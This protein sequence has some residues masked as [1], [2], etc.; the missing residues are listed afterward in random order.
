MGNDAMPLGLSMAMAQDTRAMNGFFSLSD[1]QK[2]ELIQYIKS[3]PTG[4]EAKERIENTIQLLHDGNI[5][6]KFF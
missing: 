3:S 5:Q 2:N 6:N 4:P 1:W